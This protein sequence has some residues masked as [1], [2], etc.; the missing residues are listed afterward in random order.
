MKRLDVF[1]TQIG[2]PM[3]NVKYLV[4]HKVQMHVGAISRLLNGFA[5]VRVIIHDLAVQTHKPYSCVQTKYQHSIALSL[6]SFTFLYQ[7]IMENQVRFINNLK[8]A[9]RQGPCH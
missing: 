4:M 1:P 2:I 6:E 9:R 5:P 3:F 7:R 8:N